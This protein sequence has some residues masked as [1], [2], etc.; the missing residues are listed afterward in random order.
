MIQ[1]LVHIITEH[2]APFEM[3]KM[4]LADFNVGGVGTIPIV[5]YQHHLT[6]NHRNVTLNYFPFPLLL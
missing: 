1:M 5:V 4:C 3:I 6:G 2:L